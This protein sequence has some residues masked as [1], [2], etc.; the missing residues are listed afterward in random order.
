MDIRKGFR[1]VGKGLG[2]VAK[3]FAQGINDWAEMEDKQKKE[4][5]SRRIEMHNADIMELDA[6]ALRS[7]KWMSSDQLKAVFKGKAVKIKNDPEV[8]EEMKW[9]SSAQLD[10]IFGDNRPV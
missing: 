8:W 2:A 9:M 1:A 6:E 4:Q 5:L 10:A 3:G 7:L